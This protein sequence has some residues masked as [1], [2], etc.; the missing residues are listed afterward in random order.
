[1]VRKN[2]EDEKIYE[3]NLLSRDGSSDHEEEKNSKVG[4][5]SLL[6]VGV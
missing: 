6:V 3:V 4:S 1:M 5:A 2:H